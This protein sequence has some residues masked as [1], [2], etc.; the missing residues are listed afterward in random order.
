MK[1]LVVDDDPDFS[2]LLRLGLESRGMQCAVARNGAFAAEAL[3]E[4]GDFEV[5]LLDVEM[6][7]MD[8]WQLLSELR[9]AGEEIPV[10]FVSAL[11]S[12]EH[13]VRGLR[14]GA[15][16]FLIKPVHMDELEAR[17]HAVLRRRSSLP[18]LE[19]G[20]L[21]LDLGLRKAFRGE[22]VLPLSPK[23]FDLLLALVRAKGAIK[24]RAELLEE[25]WDMP[26][27]PGTNLL[28]VHIGRLR[29][30]VDFR[31]SPLIRTERGQGYRLDA[32]PVTL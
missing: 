2:D 6:P 28:D 26:F 13:R 11:E 12:V 27:D 1:V 32:S 31:Q 21:R 18:S 4:Q 17:M 30:K 23:E 5:V 10:I 16:D 7:G 25:V 19:F 29:R 20:P 3:R 8:G 15:D 9:D 14:L 24:S 22:R